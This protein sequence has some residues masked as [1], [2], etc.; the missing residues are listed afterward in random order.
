MDKNYDELAVHLAH[1][2]IAVKG[3]THGGVPTM[4]VVDKLVAAFNALDNAHAF[5]EIDDHLGY[6]DAEDT[7]ARVAEKS[8][9]R[10]DPAEW[11]DLSGYTEV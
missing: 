2:R 3:L 6:E 5:A 4:S 11:G 8:V 1:A 9:P 7:L 10:R